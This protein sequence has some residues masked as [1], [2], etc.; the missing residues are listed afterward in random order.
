MAR[1]RKVVQIPPAEAVFILEAMVLDG[2]VST[3]TLDEYRARYVSEIHTLEARLARLK[4]LAMPAVTTA[5]GAAVAAAAP[6]VAR[7][8]R[9]RRAKKVA[10][11][12]GRAVK[13]VT[14]E[15]ILSRKL[16]GRYL[17]LMRQI[18]KTVVKQR[19]GKDAIKES[20][21]EA[22]ITEMEKYLAEKGSSAPATAPKGARGGRKARSSKRK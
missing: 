13:G 4:D 20:G 16:Q 7:A 18:P 2:N 5:I 3:S 11:R 10:A 22:V 6:A 15:R 9:G 1:P 21:K 12:I 14:P 17:G 8:V 19:F